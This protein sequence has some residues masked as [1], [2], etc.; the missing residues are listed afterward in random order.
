MSTVLPSVLDQIDQRT[1]EIL[2]RQRRS[3]SARRRGWLMR[4]MLLKSDLV[5]LAVAFAGAQTIY[6]YNVQ[7]GTFGIAGE[8][9][10]FVLTLPL[11]VVMAKLYGLY[12]HDEERADHSTADDV[13]G[14][15]HLVTVGTWLLFLGAHLTKLANPQLPKLMAFWLLAIVSVPV[16]RSLA[17]S[18]CRHSIDYLQNTLIIGAGDVG[19]QV[20][21]K[22]LHHPEYGFNLVGFVDSNPRRLIRELQH[23]TLLGSLDNVSALVKLLNI[24]RVIVAFSNDNHFETLE[25]IRDLNKLDVQVDVVPR[26]YE[27]IGPTV[28]VHSVEGMSLIGLRRPKLSRSSALLKRL[29]DLTGA[30]FGLVLLAPL[31]AVIALATRLDSA[32]GVFF[33]QVRMGS[34]GRTFRIIKFRTMTVDADARKGEFA[35]LN[36]HAHSGGDAR[37]FKIDDDPRVTRVG[38]WLRRHSLDELPQL[39]NVLRSEMSLVGPRPL[40][41]EEDAYVTDW[42]ERRLDLKPGITG[43]WQVLGRDDIPFEEMVTLDYLYVTSWSL[44][45]DLR[46]LLRTI[47]ILFRAT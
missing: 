21:R 34:G 5:G 14:V 9:L 44:G 22:V 31:F 42:A 18:R 2:K 37:M 29:L 35:F 33:R 7:T 25:V 6:A 12:E 32:G 24:E 46:L 13:V 17:R 30:L 1:V 11:W 10:L 15:F 16:L 47:P 20:A 19:Q 27:V 28:D 45:G 8:T 41:L 26:F 4:R 23:L 43:I 3:P 38:R 36:K 39:W 40:I